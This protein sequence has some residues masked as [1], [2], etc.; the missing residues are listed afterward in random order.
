MPDE[1]QLELFPRPEPRRHLRSITGCVEAHP[2]VFRLAT[3]RL[4]DPDKP[5]K[6]WVIDTRGDGDDD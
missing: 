5:E 2:N 1:N 3:A 6:G 4:K